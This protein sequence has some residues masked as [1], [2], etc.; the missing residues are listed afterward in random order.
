M[1]ICRWT[2]IP[3]GNSRVPICGGWTGLTPPTPTR[4]ATALVG[5]GL[6]LHS[7]GD[8]DAGVIDDIAQVCIREKI[9]LLVDLI[10]GEEHR[11]TWMRSDDDVGK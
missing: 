1:R 7:L 6:V 11:Q 10:N 2:E 5:H 8:G 9:C 4:V 3:G